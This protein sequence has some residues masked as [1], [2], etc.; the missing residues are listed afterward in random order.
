MIRAM[1]ATI[2]REFGRTAFG[3]D[4]G[5]YADARPDYPAR[6]YE[7][8][9][10]TC[11]AGP[12]TAAFEIGPGTGQATGRLLDIG[13]SITA[14]EPDA[15]LAAALGERLKQHAARLSILPLAF[16]DAALPASSF[17][18]GIAATSLHWLDPRTALTKAFHLLR[19]G[20]RWA[21]WW[22]VFGDPDDMDDFQRR[23][24]SLFAGLDRSPSQGSGKHF[25]LD[26]ACRIAELQATGFGAIAYEEIRWQ[27]TLD[28]R[29][30]LALTATFSPVRRL[31]P[32]ER[33]R[34]LDEM[35]RIIDEDFGGVVTRNFVTAIYTA[36]RPAS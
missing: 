13:C 9:R 27:P 24:Q 4:A 10:E 34:F 7:I 3:R 14:I 19:P 26:R 31:D 36:E 8:L 28:K 17:D 15:R 20:G 2:E 29:Q 6:V 18:L 1:P 11:R 16:E 21:M 5:A 32:P 33:E 35:A 25:S 22:T 23:T 12:R 30:V